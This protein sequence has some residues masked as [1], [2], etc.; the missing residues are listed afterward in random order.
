MSGTFEDAFREAREALA[1]LGDVLWWTIYPLWLRRLVCGRRHD[2]VT[3]DD[4][5]GI[6][7]CARCGHVSPG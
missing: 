4:R 5:A 6:W 2:R 7:G 1:W 3:L